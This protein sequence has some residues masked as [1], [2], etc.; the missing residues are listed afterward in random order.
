MGTQPDIP[1]DAIRALCLKHN[2]KALWLFGSAACGDFDPERSDFDFLVEYLPL[3]PGSHADAYFGLRFDLEDLL[4][5]TVDLATVGAVRNPYV[6]ASVER[7]RV[8]I[9]AAA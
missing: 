8:P 1:L 6:L 2:V 9:Y 7:T 4:G 3:A 5:R